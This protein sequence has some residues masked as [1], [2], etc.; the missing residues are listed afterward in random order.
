MKKYNIIY[1]DPP[2]NYN[3]KMSGHSFSLDHEY[4]TQDLEWI[5]E[6]AVKNIA[7]KDS[8]LFLW[9]VSPMLPEAI[10]VMEAWG[11][12]YKTLAFVWSKT[13]T[14]GKWVSNIGRW[15]MG[16]VELCLLGTRGKPK[17]KEKNIK[18]LVVAKRTVHSKKPD[19]IR[20]K[21]TDLMGNLSRIEL[22][23]RGDKNRD[24]FNFNK[25]DGWDTWGN[26]I[27]SDIKLCNNKI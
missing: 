24:M 1:A 20:K 13:T 22:F 2:W 10:E 8:V 11:F 16:N 9:A 21:I 23:A 17:R 4:I 27:E 25:F 6:L 14:N 3:D 19:I 26:E 7:N 5:K 15:T 12:E 18:Q